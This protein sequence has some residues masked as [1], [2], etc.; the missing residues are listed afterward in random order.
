MNIKAFLTSPTFNTVRAV[1]YVAIPA[2]LIA[3]VN[4]RKLSQDNA[5]LWVAV[6]LAALSPAIASVF[7]PG[8]LRTWVYGL[9]APVQAALIG[10]GGANNVYALVIAAVVGSLVTSG[11][12]AANVHA[13][14]T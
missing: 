1:L 8:G 2:A 6:V 9:L 10:F 5:N 4:G 12:A 14:E 3:L 13:T 7:A 11:V